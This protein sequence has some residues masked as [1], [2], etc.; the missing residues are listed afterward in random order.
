MVFLCPSEQM[1]VE[2]SSSSIFRTFDGESGW[3]ENPDLRGETPWHKVTYRN[4]YS[5][6]S[7]TVYLTVYTTTT[8]TTTTPSFCRAPGS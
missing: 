3:L 6:L 2:Y 5:E 4:H 8:T 7:I 1:Y